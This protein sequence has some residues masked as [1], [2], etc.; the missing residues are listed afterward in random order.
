M[1]STVHALEEGISAGLVCS[2][3]VCEGRGWCPC[4]GGG[5]FRRSSELPH[6]FAKED[7]GVH[8]LEEGISAGLGHCRSQ[9]LAE[10]IT[11]AH[12]P[13]VLSILV[14]SDKKLFPDPARMK[15]R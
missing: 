7:D 9:L 13:P 10:L 3:P 6:L 15:S 12:N 14:R 5:Y 11:P 2:P 8:A 4:P 1:V